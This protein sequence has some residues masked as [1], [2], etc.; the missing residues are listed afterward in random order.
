MYSLISFRY[1]NLSTSAES[2]MATLTDAYTCIPA[3]KTFLELES[4]WGILFSWCTVVVT[5]LQ[6]LYECLRD[7]VPDMGK[8]WDDL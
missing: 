3:I 4:S 5:G 1:F 2:G 7:G 8:V 6:F